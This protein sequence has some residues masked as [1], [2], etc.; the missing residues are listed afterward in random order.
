MKRTLMQMY[1]KNSAEAVDFYQEAFQASLGNNW[2]NEDGS[3]FHVELDADG[4]LLAISEATDATVQGNNLQFCFQFDET[5]KEKVRQAYE[6]LKK[7]A[8]IIR[9]LGEPSWSPYMF[10][11]IDRFGVHWCVFI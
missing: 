1:V 4:Q 10:A 8:H 9:D 11:L 3:C 2:R 7:D 5:E 6:V